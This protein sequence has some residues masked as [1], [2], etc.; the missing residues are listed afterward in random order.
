MTNPARSSDPEVGRLAVVS[1]AV[2]ELAHL[3][4]GLIVP[5]FLGYLALLG[6]AA[7]VLGRG[8]GMPIT[9]AVVMCVGVFAAQV[10]HFL[11]VQSVAKRLEATQETASVL[12][13]EVF[14]PDHKLVGVLY[15]K[16]FNV[17][18]WFLWPVNLLVLGALFWMLTSIEQPPLL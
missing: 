17:G 14:G 1:E 11:I 9:G 4:L 5:Y 7:S 10:G 6:W 13:R 16:L 12:A 2:F 8:Q 18:F 15:A 3:L